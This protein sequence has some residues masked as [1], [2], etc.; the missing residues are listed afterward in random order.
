[1]FSIF[2]ACEAGD[3][4][5]VRELVAANLTVVNARDYW[6]S[7]PLHSATRCGRLEVAKFLVG[8]GA[9]IHAKNDYG[10][11]ALHLASWYDRLDIV[12]FL[13]SRGANVNAKTDHG[14]TS[15]CGAAMEGNLD[16]VLYLWPL[17]ASDRED[18][19]YKMIGKLDHAARVCL[20]LAECGFTPDMIT[21]S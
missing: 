13:V 12:K 2:A 6:R 11:T 1:M 5:V 7:T 19:K 4:A 20:L 3:L 10:A 18:K 8:K 21:F 17:S 9:D 14:I 16:V 15:L